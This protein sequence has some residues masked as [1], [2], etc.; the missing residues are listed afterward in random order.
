LA[1]YLLYVNDIIDADQEMNQDTLPR[2]T[3]PNEGGFH[4]KQRP[5][6]PRHEPCMENCRDDV[7]I[8]GRATDIGVTPEEET[9]QDEADMN[10]ADA[11]DSDDS[12]SQLAGDP[13]VG[14][15]VFRQCAGCHTIEA[16]EAH[17]MGPNLHDVVGRESGGAEGFGGYSEAMKE[18]D[19]VWNAESLKQYLADPQG[20]MPGTRMPFNGIKDEQALRDLIAYLQANS[21]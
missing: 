7:T 20:F 9:P 21:S 17:R 13:E 12:G 15:R 8:I 19:V 11:G 5:E 18:S 16:G 1:A 10:G 2:V 6:F 14:H 4:R 3:M